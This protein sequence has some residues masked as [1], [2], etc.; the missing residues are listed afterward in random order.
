MDLDIGS[1]A[2]EREVDRIAILTCSNCPQELDCAAVVC[3]GDMRK[4]KGFFDRYEADGNLVLVGM[5]NCAG[6]QTL[7][8]PGQNTAKSEVPC[9]LPDGRS[10]LS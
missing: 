9:G 10:S 5:V 8:S 1:R 2:V 3:L 4:R 6:Y 7:A